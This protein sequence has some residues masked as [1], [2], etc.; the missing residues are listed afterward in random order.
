MRLKTMLI[1]RAVKQ[2]RRSARETCHRMARLPIPKTSKTT[3]LG[4]MSALAIPSPRGLDDWKVFTTFF[5]PKRPNAPSPLFG[6]GCLINTNDYF[7]D[8]GIYD[9]TAI[10]RRHEIPFE[11]E[12]AY[13]ASRARAICDLVLDAALRGT[14]AESLVLNDWMPMCRDKAEL[15]DVLRPAF[16]KMSDEVFFGVERWMTRN[17]VC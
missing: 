14:V 15:F 4:G 16:P 9:C 13:A 17:G 8:K 10:L 11:G 5:L 12:V 1:E 7:G 6:E 3:Y 2:I